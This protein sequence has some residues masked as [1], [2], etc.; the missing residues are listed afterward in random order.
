MN[1][2]QLYLDTIKG[3]IKNPLFIMAAIGMI[4]LYINGDING[5]IGAVLAFVGVK[6]IVNIGTPTSPDDKQLGLFEHFI[7]SSRTWVAAVGCVICYY[8]RMPEEMKQILIA[9]PVGFGLDWIAVYVKGIDFTKLVR[10]ADQPTQI[11]V[12]LQQPASVPLISPPVEAPP[13]FTP[14][15]VVIPTAQP[16]PDHVAPI[17]D[18]WPAM[19][20]DWDKFKQ[21]IKDA[22]DT[23][24]AERIRAGKIDG[25]PA[26]P[27][28]TKDSA[29]AMY[30]IQ[31][32]DNPSMIWSR[33]QLRGMLTPIK[34]NA[35]AIAFY[36][37]AFLPAA[38]DALVD[39][40]KQTSGVIK[41]AWPPAYQA[42]AW[43]QQCRKSIGALQSI[44]AHV[45][46]NNPATGKNIL[47]LSGQF[48]WF[49]GEIAQGFVDK[50]IP[51][52]MT[53]DFNG[54]PVP[55]YLESSN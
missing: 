39:Q 51:L 43:V 7:L 49:A 41:C 17:K 24:L 29:R 11:I 36:Q 42:R 8:N 15:V 14:P 2:S 4:S 44:T 47:D 22:V 46:I 1:K 30:P 45:A 38:E 20:T 53:K 52:Y 37:M 3:A 32:S 23:E 35:D 50:E 21:D 55:V 6:T 18:K 31:S 10:K 27:N 13:T 16:E 26:N 40:Q 33:T 5:V 48:A 25:I 19:P 9:L 54:L 34:S 12:G 28:I